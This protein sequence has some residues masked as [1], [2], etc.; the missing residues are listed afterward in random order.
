MHKPRRTAEE[1]FP[2]V[3]YY[4]QGRQSLQAFCVEHAISAS[5]FYYWRRKYRQK[6]QGEGFIEVGLPAAGERAV[7]EI[8]YPGGVRLRLFAP[9]S[10]AWLTALLRKEEAPV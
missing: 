6:P 4:L 1:M 10:R 2:L 5:Q 3:E 7:M 8:V 9:I